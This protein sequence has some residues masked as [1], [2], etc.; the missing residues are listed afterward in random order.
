MNW[1]EFWLKDKMD[2]VDNLYSFSLSLSL[3]IYFFPH[4][5]THPC[6]PV[7]SQTLSIKDIFLSFH[8]KTFKIV[9]CLIVKNTC[10]CRAKPFWTRSGHV[11]SSYIVTYPNYYSIL[12]HPVNF[13]CV[14]KTHDFRQSVDELFPRA[15]RCSIQCL[16]PW[17]QWWEDVS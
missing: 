14:E 3:Y 16:N 4:N 15:I 12:T 1:L 8:R 2:D 5:V 13:P 6:F 17:L 7:G 9:E 10:I 11:S